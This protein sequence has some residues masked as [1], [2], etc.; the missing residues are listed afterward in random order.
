M[1]GQDLGTAAGPRAGAPPVAAT[2]LRAVDRRR[3]RACARYAR[4]A[5][6]A[7][8]GQGIGF[9]LADGQA[10][11]RELRR[12]VADSCLHLFLPDALSVSLGECAPSHH[13]RSGG[14]LDLCTR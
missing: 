3:Y 8:T 4:L 10:A 11:L 7:G 5:G 14:A 2:I 6:G 12:T 9:D 1:D 13:R